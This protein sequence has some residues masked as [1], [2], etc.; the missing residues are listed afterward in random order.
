MQ[1]GRDDKMLHLKKEY[2][3]IRGQTWWEKLLDLFTREYPLNQ[4]EMVVFIATGIGMILFWLLFEVFKV[5]FSRRIKLILVWS[6]VGLV[7]L[8]YL[9]WGAEWLGDRVERLVKRR[10]SEKIEQYIAEVGA[11]S[12]DELIGAVM[13]IRIHRGFDKALKE[14]EDARKFAFYDGVIRLPT[15]EDKK[16]WRDWDIELYGVSFAELEQVF[17]HPVEWFGS[18]LRI[19]FS[20][21]ED[22]VHRL[23]K[24]QTVHTDA[25]LYVCTVA[26]EERREFTS[27]AELAVAPIFNGKNLREVCNRICVSYANNYSW[28]HEFFEENSTRP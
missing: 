3:P 17:A 25:E 23:E 6:E 1:K 22:E 12:Y 18:E 26:G 11:C 28:P 20:I 15:D 4:I 16:R 2:R 7:C 27:F 13:K 19:E 9:L 5:D 10:V 24:I 21:W 14:F 8:A